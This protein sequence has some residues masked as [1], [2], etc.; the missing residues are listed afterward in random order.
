M[1]IRTHPVERLRLLFE[2]LVE[3]RAAH[4]RQLGRRLD[5]TRIRRSREESL[6]ALENYVGALYRCG[7]PIPPALH[8][9]LQLLRGLCAGPRRGIPRVPAVTGSDPGSR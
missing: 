7:L 6:A 5:P 2:R 3:A 8:R 1:P 9:D 4:R